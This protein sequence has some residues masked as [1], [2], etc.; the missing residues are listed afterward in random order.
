MFGWWNRKVFLV[1]NT[2]IVGKSEST[3]S[4][5][6]FLNSLS[7]AVSTVGL[8]AWAH[9]VAAGSLLVLAG[10]ITYGVSKWVSQGSTTVTT[11]LS[12]IQPQTPTNLP[13]IDIFL[14]RSAVH[15]ILR[16]LRKEVRKYFSNDE[17]ALDALVQYLRD[18]FDGVKWQDLTNLT[19]EAR[20]EVFHKIILTHYRLHHNL[21]LQE[22]NAFLL[23]KEELAI[24]LHM[25]ALQ[26]A[27]EFQRLLEFGFIL[28]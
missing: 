12:L 18:G 14:P 5:E 26:C 3:S 8:W 27:F 20:V 21:T 16:G 2:I 28:L 4:S 13:E 15:V 22:L 24:S 17:G 25:L 7:G 23:Q 19:R 9:P 6:I 11:D 1:Y 10:L